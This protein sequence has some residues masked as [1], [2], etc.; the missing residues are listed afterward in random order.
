MQYPL[1]VSA[2]IS[3]GHFKKEVF[4][5]E[6]NQI[7]DLYFRRSESAIS[8]T[9]RKYGPYCYS[10]SHNI[11]H[12]KEDAEETVSDTYLTAWNSMPPQRPPVLAAFLGRITRHLAIDR[13]R[14]GRTLKRGGGE[15]PLALD[16]LGECASGKPTPETV[17]EG[18]QLS[19]AFQNFLNMLPKTERQIFLCR[20]FYLDSI[21]AISTFT[22]FSSSKVTSMLHRTRKK[23]KAHLKK[24]GYL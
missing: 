1:P 22:G 3:E 16:E 23:L 18:R 8:E 4:Q 6:D 17:L 11:L 2:M 5:M 10:I 19:E 15:I 20:Y 14:S 24:E 9:D 12:N 13:W 21:A 7:I